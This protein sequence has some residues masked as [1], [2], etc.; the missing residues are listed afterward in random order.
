MQVN[1]TTK[2]LLVTHFR[3]GSTF[4]GQLF[5]QNPE[6]FY[7]FEPFAT[8][9]NQVFKDRYLGVDVTGNGLFYMPDGEPM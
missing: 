1:Q 7:W 8:V 3:G 5:N 9:Y 6:A 2:V 4:L